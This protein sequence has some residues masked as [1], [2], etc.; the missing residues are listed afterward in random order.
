MLKRTFD[1]ILLLGVAVV[2]IAVGRLNLHVFEFQL[3]G[4]V[5]LLCGTAVVLYFWRT[6]ESRADHHDTREGQDE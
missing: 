4:G 2:L 3:F 5:M 6:G 1:L